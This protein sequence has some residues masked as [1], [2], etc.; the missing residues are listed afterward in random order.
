MT[1]LAQDL[2][3]LSVRREWRRAMQECLAQWR[4]VCAI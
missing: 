4:R 1:N 2:F 3:Y